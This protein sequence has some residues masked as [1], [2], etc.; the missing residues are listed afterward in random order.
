MQ[1]IETELQR[2]QVAGQDIEYFF[3]MI[4]TNIIIIEV[5]RMDDKN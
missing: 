4:N 3:I 5:I 2:V 1:A